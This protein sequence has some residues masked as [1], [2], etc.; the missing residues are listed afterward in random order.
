MKD[1]YKNE[2]IFENDQVSSD[3]SESDSAASADEESCTEDSSYVKTLVKRVVDKENEYD[4][5]KIYQ[6]VVD[7]AKFYYNEFKNQEDDQFWQCLKE[8]A[9]TYKDKN[10]EDIITTNAAF[11]MALKKYK[12]VIKEYIRD[13][14]DINDEVISED[15]TQSSAEDMSEDN[16]DVENS[17]NNQTL[18]KYYLN[19]TAR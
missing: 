13:E 4:E 18:D 10:P 7:K 19:R 9:D 2:D 16:S 5:N 1:N 12:P 11:E 3:D 8:K 6:D 17:S 15:D 14:L